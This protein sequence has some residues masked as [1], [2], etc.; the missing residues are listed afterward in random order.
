MQEPERLT[1][2]QLQ[3]KIIGENVRKFPCEGKT[4]TGE[5]CSTGPYSTKQSMQGHMRQKHPTA[6][7]SGITMASI[8]SPSVSSLQTPT[9]LTLALPSPRSAVRTLDKD[10]GAADND[11]FLAEAVKDQELC[12]ELDRVMK[13]LTDQQ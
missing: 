7:P 11:D 13:E 5:P 4:D 2:S 12:D 1:I 3:I 9:A 10:L 8:S 6:G